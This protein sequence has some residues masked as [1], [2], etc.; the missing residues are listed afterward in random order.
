MPAEADFPEAIC[1]CGGGF[2][3]IQ[4]AEWWKPDWTVKWDNKRWPK[5]SR[6][7][8]SPLIGK[9]IEVESKCRNAS[10]ALREPHFVRTREDKDE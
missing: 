8:G 1:K 9:T 3:K 7:G 2:T 5:V 6:F 10:G 4:R